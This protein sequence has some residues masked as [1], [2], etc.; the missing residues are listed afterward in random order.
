MNK[1]DDIITLKAFKN[2]KM[3]VSVK[4][5]INTR[6]SKALSSLISS[7]DPRRESKQL[8]SIRSLT[9]TSRVKLR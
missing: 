4:R 1:D 6:L 8:V 3:N 2:T 9:L 7:V 5:E